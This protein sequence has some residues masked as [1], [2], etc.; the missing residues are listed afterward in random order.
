MA[1]D[2]HGACCYRKQKG[3]IMGFFKNIF[4]DAM[5]ELVDNDENNVD[6]ELDAKHQEI[7]DKYVGLFKEQFE[8]SY[9]AFTDNFLYEKPNELVPEN[10][11]KNLFENIFYIM[12]DEDIFKSLKKDPEK[13]AKHIRRVFL[14]LP[15]YFYKLK[16][17]QMCHAVESKTKEDD[18]FTLAVMKNVKAHTTASYD[19][20]RKCYAKND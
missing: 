19:K 10:T 17:D 12:N 8:Q 9:T 4:T 5:K 2:K 7:I 11:Q 6:N 20:D 3:L 1:Q 15:I 16:I 14:W 18:L 13:F